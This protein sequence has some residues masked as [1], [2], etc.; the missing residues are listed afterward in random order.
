MGRDAGARPA[1]GGD[2]DDPPGEGYSGD[3]ATAPL[4]EPSTGRVGFKSAGAGAN[5]R[6]WEQ[7]RRALG[8]LVTHTAVREIRV[9]SEL[10]SSVVRSK[11]LAM[12][13]VFGGPDDHLKIHV[14]THSDGVPAAAPGADGINLASVATVVSGDAALTRTD[15][16]SHLVEVQYGSSSDR[17]LERKELEIVVET[18]S[19]SPALTGGQA[20]RTVPVIGRLPGFGP[21]SR[22]DPIR[23]V[24]HPSPGNLVAALR[25][26]QAVVRSAIDAA[27][28]TPMVRATVGGRRGLGERKAERE[29]LASSA[30]IAVDRVELIGVFDKIPVTAVSRLSVEEQAA[31]LMVWLLPE[32]VR[33]ASPPKALTLL[34]GRDTQ[35]GKMIQTVA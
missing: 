7:I 4:P 12:A 24:V 26:A 31:E 3:G 10:L 8:R 11:T 21:E 32:A 30:K 13:P 2:D 27:Y 19:V 15:C 34:I 14:L 23:S 6:L 1:L 28:G 29:R 5:N 22:I 25:P 20:S 33:A 17:A 35:T 18:S 9:G 16:P